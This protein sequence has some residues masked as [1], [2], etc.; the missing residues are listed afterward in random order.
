[1]I[2]RCM[3]VG[4]ST[5]RFDQRQDAPNWENA[6]RCA[7]LMS[8][9][10]L[11]DISTCKLSNLTPV[12]L[13]QT[14]ARLKPSHSNCLNHPEHGM[15]TVARAQ[16]A[17]SSSRQPAHFRIERNPQ[18]AF[19]RQQGGPRR[20]SCQVRQ[21]PPPVPILS[22]ARHGVRRCRNGVAEELSCTQRLRSSSHIGLSSVLVHRL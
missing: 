13:N 15:S 3:A 8:F 17:T 14:K 7:S 10:I 20:P 9:G 4:A 6:S 22:P 19:Y 21:L 18:V 16:R 5:G 11:V 12:S 2:R 1:M